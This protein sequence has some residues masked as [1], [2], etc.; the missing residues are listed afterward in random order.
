MS[1]KSV[2]AAAISAVLLL[3][4]SGSAHA[5][6]QAAGRSAVG[7]QAGCGPGLNGGVRW[8]L[9]GL[10]G[11]EYVDLCYAGRPFMVSEEG[12][13]D[14]EVQSSEV[15]LGIG[16]M[17]RLLSTRSRSAVLSA[18]GGLGIGVVYA[19]DLPL[20]GGVYDDHYG[21]M[22]ELMPEVDMEVF[23][24]RNVSLFAM[25]RPKIRISETLGAVEKKKVGGER[26]STGV[27]L[28]RPWF[29]LTAGVGLR[30]Y[31]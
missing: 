11:S 16:Y 7:F 2:M 24:F 30:F 10:S 20:G 8:D 17:H 18:G 15:T 29:N 14:Y 3:L 13:D 31:W 27:V 6:R 28:H 25:V 22:A 12:T 21:V 19:L 1:V 26:V 23:P 4:S 9:F 5:Q